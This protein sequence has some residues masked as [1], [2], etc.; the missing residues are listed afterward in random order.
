M[1]PFCPR[2]RD[3]ASR[4]RRTGFAS[5][6]VLVASTEKNGL[7]TPRALLY[8]Y[9]YVFIK[10]LKKKTEEQPGTGSAG[11]CSTPGRRWRW[12]RQ[13]TPALAARC[14]VL[15]RCRGLQ[16]PIRRPTTRWMTSTAGGV[17]LQWRSARKAPWRGCKGGAQVRCALRTEDKSCGRGGENRH[18]CRATRSALQGLR[19]EGFEVCRRQRFAEQVA[20]VQVAAAVAQQVRCCFGF[21]PLRRSHP[22]P[23][24]APCR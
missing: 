8:Y 2:W 10:T 13:E 23:G 6:Q 7:S 15:V 20:L 16:R 14:G 12:K 9:D 22:A 17:A 18:R 3:S 5:T 4:V 24:C 19:E 1:C 21:P 11:P